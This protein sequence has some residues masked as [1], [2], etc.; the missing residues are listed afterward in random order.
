MKCVKSRCYM[1]FCCAGNSSCDLSVRSPCS[2]CWWGACLAA[3]L[4]ETISVFSTIITTLDNQ[5]LII[6]NGS[7]TSGVIRNYT[8]N[9]TRRLDLV[10][11]ISYSDDIKKAKS[12]LG[13]ILVA[14]RR[15][16]EDPAPVI[17]VSELGES[18]VDFV[19]RPW[20]KTEEYWDVRGDL[21]EKIKLTFDEK[22]I[23][24]PYP[25]RDVHMISQKTG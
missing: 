2:F 24:I 22:G 1:D 17:A 19:V 23:S 6:P 10:I 7:I 13:D 18:S 8:A 11:G 9:D 16:L 21:I 20:V 25:Q 3:G 12:I 5:C 4:V 14:D 15:I